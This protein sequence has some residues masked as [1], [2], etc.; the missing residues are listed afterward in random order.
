MKTY[1]YKEKLSDFYFTK[2]TALRIES[3]ILQPTGK[4]NHN[5]FLKKKSYMPHI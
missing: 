2:E 5:Q 4:E 3:L 1:L